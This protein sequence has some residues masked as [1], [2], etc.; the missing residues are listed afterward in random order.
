MKR[1]HTQGS[2]LTLERSLYPK[3]KLFK[4]KRIPLTMS[5]YATVAYVV[6]QVRAI[7]E[8][9]VPLTREERDQYCPPQKGSP[10]TSFDDVDLKNWKQVGIY[11]VR[12]VGLEHAQCHTNARFGAH[13]LWRDDPDS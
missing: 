12:Q 8:Q 10:C 6:K 7:M 3:A 11:W 5:A 2:E 4:P 9:E 13:A 1:Y